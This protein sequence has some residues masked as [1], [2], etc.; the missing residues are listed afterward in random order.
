M[1][2]RKVL[3]DTVVLSNYTGERDGV[4]TYQDTVLEHCRCRFSE[5]TNAT[6]TGKMAGDSATLY[7]FDR[8]TKAKSADGAPRTFLPHEDF[9]KAEDKASYWTLSDAGKDKFRVQGRQ[10]PLLIKSLVHR[11]VGSRR[12]WHF[13]VKAT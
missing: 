2:S 7:I 8:A 11:V 4:A 13:E 3:P 1:A 12:M 5:G 10:E 6:G 9:E